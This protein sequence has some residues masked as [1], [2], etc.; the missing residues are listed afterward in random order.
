MAE[1]DVNYGGKKYTVTGAGSYSDA[2]HAAAQQ[3]HVDTAVDIMTGGSSGQSVAGWLRDKAASRAAEIERRRIHVEHLNALVPSYRN[4]N[5]DEV[6]N[7]RFCYNDD[8]R[9]AA[10]VAIAYAKKGNYEEALVEWMSSYEI[11]KGCIGYGYDTYDKHFY[12]NGYSGIA[13]TVLSDPDLYS[14]AI[15]AVKQAYFTAKGQGTAD[16]DFNQ[17]YMSICEREL[18]G[19]FLEFSKT[20]EYNLTLKLQY[21]KNKWSTLCGQEMSEEEYKG[22][23]CGD[24][25]KLLKTYKRLEAL[26]QALAKKRRKPRNGFVSLIFGLAGGFGAALTVDWVFVKYVENFSPPFV[27]ALAASVI[28][29]F[30]ALRRRHNILFI[31]ML[32]LSIPGWL[33]LFG[34]L[35]NDNLTIMTYISIFKSL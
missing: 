24:N 25:K 27:I 10:L 6:I 26:E 14:K 31:V 12:D 19:N 7:H 17:Y 20:W 32:A 21:W 33:A 9:V 8:R 1:Y 3:S 11:T 15:E 30:H 16:S 23:A 2:Q 5:W 29:T 22:I 13:V 35:P 28:L 4:G 34:V 18:K